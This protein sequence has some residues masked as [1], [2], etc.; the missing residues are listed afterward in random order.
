MD[1]KTVT[2]MVQ[3]MGDLYAD[4]WRATGGKGSSFLRSKGINSVE[5]IPRVAGE[6]VM[7]N[8]GWAQEAMKDLHGQNEGNNLRDVAAAVMLENPGTPPHLAWTKA[9]EILAGFKSS[10][11]VVSASGRMDVDKYNA[12]VQSFINGAKA[13]GSVPDGKSQ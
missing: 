9:G 2:L 12:M 5:D 6:V 4:V 7:A 10:S 1:G 11:G 3:T 13:P 8:L